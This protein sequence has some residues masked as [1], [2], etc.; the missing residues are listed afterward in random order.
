MDFRSLGKWGY[1]GE[2]ILLIYASATYF[3]MAVISG[4]SLSQPVSPFATGWGS[5]AFALVAFV[6]GVLVGLAWFGAGKVGSSGLFKA[7]GF[8]GLLTSAGGL[9]ITIWLAKAFSSAG[10]LT[11]GTGPLATALLFIFAA[12]AIGAVGLVYLILET[13][14]FFSARG[15]FN[16]KYFRYAGWARIIAICGV[17][18]LV[19]FAILA[20]I[21]AFAGS[22]TPGGSVASTTPDLSFFTRALDTG[23]AFLL[24]VW[25]LPDVFAALGFR[26][27]QVAEPVPMAPLNPA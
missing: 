7:T 8:L 21:L 1:L 26:D 27:S 9:L 22:V 25:A 15:A 20:A 17:G 14:S 12:L 11:S 10:S 18:G 19:V 6:P 23:V 16:S 13:I 2:A 5:V 3:Y 4:G 24:F